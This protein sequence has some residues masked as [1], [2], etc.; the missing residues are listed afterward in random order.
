VDEALLP[1]GHDAVDRVLREHF[2][3]GSAHHQS[4]SV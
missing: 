4:P 3:R 2:V 1:T